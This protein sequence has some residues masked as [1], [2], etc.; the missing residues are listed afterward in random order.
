MAGSRLIVP[1]VCVA[2]V[3]GLGQL[4]LLDQGPDWLVGKV[5]WKG[6]QLPLVSF[7]VACGGELPDIGRRTRAVIFHA[8]MGLQG[9]FF[10]IL[11]QGLPQLVRI[12]AGVV[13]AEPGQ[14]WP[15]DA[16]VLCRIRMVNEFPVVPDLE[17]L[18]AM[19]A[20]VDQD[21]R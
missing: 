19:L 9:G 18:E 6:R 2:E 17:A 10:A 7:E 12:N 16:P 1:R 4:N 11:S 20:E 21:W 13:S 3:S 8:T 14:D 5:G 15:D